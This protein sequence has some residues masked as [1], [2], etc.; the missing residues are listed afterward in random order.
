MEN[1]SPM[2][3]FNLV[4]YLMSVRDGTKNRTGPKSLMRDILAEI[5]PDYITSASKSGPTMP[6]DQWYGEAN[7]GSSARAFVARNRD[8]IGDLISGELAGKL[9][10]DELYE[11]RVGAMRTFALRFVIWAKINVLNSCADDGMSFVQLME[12]RL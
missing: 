11:G 1:R 5:L 10:D 6:L 12:S 8:M 4:E 7:F 9:Q 3:D 2:L